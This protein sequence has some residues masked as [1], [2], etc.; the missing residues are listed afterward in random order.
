M[1][2][3][4]I[5]GDG[6]IRRQGG[7]ELIIGSIEAGREPGGS[8]NRIGWQAR[9]AEEL[10]A[11]GCPRLFREKEI[12]EL[13]KAPTPRD[14]HVAP[15]DLVPQ[16]GQDGTFVGAAIGGGVGPHKSAQALGE[17]GVLQRLREGPTPL[18]FEG[19]AGGQ[20]LL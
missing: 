11:L 9:F 20:G 18:R 1:P 14:P 19:A 13:P 7:E 16:G 10:L 2:A 8:C 6:R 17:T 12:V 4:L 5:E 15:L 3:S